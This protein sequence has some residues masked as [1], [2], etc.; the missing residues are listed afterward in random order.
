MRKTF[1]ERRLASYSNDKNV[2]AWEI[3]KDYYTGVKD[4]EELVYN[5]QV[6]INKKGFLKAAKHVLR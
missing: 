4:A 1:Y 2:L 5:L 6:P 3:E